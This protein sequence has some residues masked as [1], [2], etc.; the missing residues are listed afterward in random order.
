MFLNQLFIL[1]LQRGYFT[2]SDALEGAGG[3]PTGRRIRMGSPEWRELWERS[4]ERFT[5][6]VRETVPGIRFV[7][8]E[9]VLSEA[10]GDLAGREPFP[11]AGSIRAVNAVLTDCYRVLE[12]LCPGADVFS[13][14]EDDLYFT[15]RKY[16]YGAIPSHLNELFNQSMAKRIEERIRRKEK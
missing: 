6:R 13:V 5:R 16:E 2:L 15:D 7:I 11:E 4:A 10:V 9:D 8:L 1:E 3:I 12:W 14:R